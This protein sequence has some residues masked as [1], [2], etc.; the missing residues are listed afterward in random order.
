MKQNT[1][2]NVFKL[3]KVARM[4]R[5]VRLVRAIPELMV[6]IKGMVMAARSVLLTMMLLSL[7]IYV[8]GI[9]LRTL[10]QDTDVGKRY[11]TNVPVSMKTLLLHG[12]FLEEL[13]T[14]VN[15]TSELHWSLGV[16]VVI[17]ALLASLTVMN[18][19]VGVLCEVV[20][21]VAAIEKE[22][23]QVN[24]VKAKVQETLRDVDCADD[25]NICRLDFERVLAQPVAAR[26]LQDVG[27]D[28][29]GLVDFAD[30][31]FSS[32][33]SISFEDFME[34]VLQLRGSNMSTVKDIVNLRKC[35]L[36]EFTRVEN[37]LMDACGLKAPGKDEIRLGRQVKKSAD[38]VPSRFP[39]PPSHPVGF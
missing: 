8:F 13:P 37:S 25:A 22:T 32:K 5:L 10:T 30:F 21:C 7:I 34:T 3:L 31:I 27:V 2:L 33:N 29:V 15:E 6:L 4:A 38:D 24:F 9:A 28:V 14:V 16:I 11:W 18:L 26:A 35:M 19:L 23:V 12:C 1:I 39:L 20:S 36:L 17:F